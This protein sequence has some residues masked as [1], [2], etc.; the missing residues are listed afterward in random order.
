[1]RRFCTC[2]RCT[3]I[4]ALACLAD[5]IQLPLIAE[6]LAALVTV[7]PENSEGYSETWV[8]SAVSA[9]QGGN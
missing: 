6:A 1:M 7:I 4:A 8:Q 5:E 9:D 2:E 3:K